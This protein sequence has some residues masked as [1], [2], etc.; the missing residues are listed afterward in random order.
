MCESPDSQTHELR[1]RSDTTSSDMA[2]KSTVTS[3][4]SEAA[5]ATV[6]AGVWRTSDARIQGAYLHL[7]GRP[8]GARQTRRRPMRCMHPHGCLQNTTELINGGRKMPMRVQDSG[9]R[10]APKLDWS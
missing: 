7:A 6:A 10:K 3:A 5:L 2:S 1:P 4:R 8:G 9:G